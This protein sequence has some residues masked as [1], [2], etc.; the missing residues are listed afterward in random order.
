MSGPARLSCALSVLDL[1]PVLSGSTAAGAMAD[2]LALARRVDELGYTRYW[3]AEHHGMGGIASSSPE[4]IIGHVAGVTRRI[5]VGSGGIMLPNHAALKVAESFLTLEA[6][7]P[8]RIDLGLGRAPGTGERTAVAL[9]G[10]VDAVY[11][12]R[13]PEQLVELQGFLGAGFE[14]GHPFEHVRAMPAD[15]GKPELWMLGSTDYGA[16]FAA[17]RGM[18][19]AF[20]QHFSPLPAEQVLEL[21]RTLFKPSAALAKP[22]AIV[23]IS[24]V[25]APTDDEAQDLSMSPELAFHL[26]RQ[27]GI[28]NPLPTVAEARA[29]EPDPRAWRHIRA[30]RMPRFVGSPVTVQ[31][32]LT[33]L[34]EGSGADEVMVLTMVHDQAAR[35]RSY[36]L[37][38]EMVR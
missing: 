6:F 17:E 11:E 24:A 2:T 12:D 20:A 38:R 3:L 32:A 30:A 33:R 31:A 4:I 28:S 18:P 13:F 19:Y 36:E 34:V 1:C 27:T 10:S 37:L 29:A 8:G 16:R 5:R 21:Y 15:G 26:F 25:C 7:H 14:P 22:R 23:A 9:R 35:R